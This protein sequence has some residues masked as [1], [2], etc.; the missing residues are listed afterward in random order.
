MQPGPWF[1]LEFPDKDIVSLNRSHTE[2]SH[3]ITFS[4]Y[5]KITE[6]SSIT[7]SE[8]SNFLEIRKNFLISRLQQWNFIFHS[9]NVT[10]FCRRNKWFEK[11]F[12]LPEWYRWLM[13]AMMMRHIPDQNGDYLL[14][15]QRKIMIQFS[16]A[17][18]IRSLP[19]LYH[20]LPTQ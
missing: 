17:L 13:H 20:M 19:I 6:A 11:V 10:T 1:I 4:I 16:Y 18:E 14:I 12:Q 7:S 3:T 15:F 9:G 5:H 2:Q 8:I